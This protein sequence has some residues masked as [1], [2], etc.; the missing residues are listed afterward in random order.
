MWAWCGPG[1]GM[2]LM[3]VFPLLFFLVMVVIF[4]GVAVVLLAIQAIEV[5][6]VLR[7]PVIGRAFG[8][9]G[10]FVARS[11][12]LGLFSRQQCHHSE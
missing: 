10:L 11:L 5:L 4:L 9:C 3:W 6:Q 8:A 7:H 2:G 12:G 1:T